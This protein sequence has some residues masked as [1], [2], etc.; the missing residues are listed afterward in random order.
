MSEQVKKWQRMFG[1]LNAKTKPKKIS[2]ITGFSLRPP[3]S[4]DL[5]P[6][7]MLYEAF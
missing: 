5:N 6:L 3:S 7:I 4:Q 1:L 2:E